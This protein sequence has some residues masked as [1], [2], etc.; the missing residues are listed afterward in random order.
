MLKQ[1]ILKSGRVLVDLFT[2]IDLLLLIAFLIVGT[3]FIFAG[4][5][6]LS[7][8][9]LYCSILF[10]IVFVLFFISVITK[11]VIYLLIDIKDNLA[12]VANTTDESSTKIVD[13]LTTILSLFFSAI[14][15]G[16]IVSGV[17]FYNKTILNQTG[18]FTNVEIYNTIKNRN[19]YNDKV[20]VDKFGF[21]WNAKAK[22]LIITDVIPDS[23]ASLAGL[24]KGDQIIKVN[25]LDTSILD[26]TKFIKQTKKK[27][28]VITYKR[29]GIV[30]KVQLISKPLFVQNL[31][32]HL[33]PGLYF[34]S[35]KFKNNYALGY[36][37]IPNSDNTYKKRGVICNC[38][39]QN[40]SITTFWDGLYSD[41]K[42]VKEYNYLLENNLIEENINP[43][44]F[45]SVMWDSVCLLHKQN[46]EK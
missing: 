20:L 12:K 45:G 11:F 5:T 32:P 18:N 16:L 9:I 30:K 24:K 46:S 21:A 38:D 23:A 10:L 8:K 2:A 19:K 17:M 26:E 44:T 42:F 22:N 28:I 6:E 36:F 1:I 41:N 25:N 43:N 15:L 29:A 34:N 7:I 27:K 35:V 13:F 40:P 14:I 37:K 39:E 3:F 31:P 33:V 4:D